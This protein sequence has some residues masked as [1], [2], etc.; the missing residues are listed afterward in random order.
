MLMN[1]F[2]FFSN[3]Y[4]NSFESLKVLFSG[5]AYG[6]TNFV[7]KFIH[8]FTPLDIAPNVNVMLW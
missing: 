5:K 8:S 1:L 4:C 6:F 3:F 2:V 7:A